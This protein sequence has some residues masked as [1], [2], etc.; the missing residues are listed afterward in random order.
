MSINDELGFL[1]FFKIESKNMSS[2]SG[3]NTKIVLIV[4]RV[5]QRRTQQLSTDV[6]LTQFYKTHTFQALSTL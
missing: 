6:F 3:D 5:N 4:N 1:G 2:L